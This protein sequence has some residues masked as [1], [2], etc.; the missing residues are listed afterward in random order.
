MKLVCY[1]EGRMGYRIGDVVHVPDDTVA[2]DQSNFRVVS[3]D[4]EEKQKAKELAEH[5]RLVALRQKLEKA[6]NDSAP[7]NP[8]AE[9]EKAEG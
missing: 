4:E 1:R 8:A 9:A 3:D 7:A 5:E 6:E 2:F